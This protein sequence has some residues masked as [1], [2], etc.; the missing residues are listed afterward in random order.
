MIERWNGSNWTRVGIP[1]AGRISTVDGVAT[2]S[3]SNLSAV[4]RG[5]LLR[6]HGHDNDH[7]ASAGTA[8]PGSAAPG[9]NLTFPRR[10][11]PVTATSTTDA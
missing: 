7:G 1:S 9:P 3:A 2:T 8:Y 10:A 11:T 5:P 4:G 6:C